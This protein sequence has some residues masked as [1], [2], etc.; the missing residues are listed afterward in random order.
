MTYPNVNEL[1]GNNNKPAVN[2]VTEI[3]LHQD[4]MVLLQLFGHGS[5]GNHGNHGNQEVGTADS[6]VIFLFDQVPRDC[7]D[8]LK[9]RMAR[10]VKSVTCSKKRQTFCVMRTYEEQDR[11]QDE[12]DDC[13]YCDSPA[14]PPGKLNKAYIDWARKL[15]PFSGSPVTLRKSAMSAIRVCWYLE[16]NM[17]DTMKWDDLSIMTDIVEFVDRLLKESPTISGGTSLRSTGTSYPSNA[18]RKL[19]GGSGKALDEVLLAVFESDYD[20]IL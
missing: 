3:L 20:P 5:H 17:Q 7:V 16:Q 14:L 15:M 19:R 8:V 10:L 4:S 13:R 1:C 6:S 2:K 9:S 18:V 11:I 12:D